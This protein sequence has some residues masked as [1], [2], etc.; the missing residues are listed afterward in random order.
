MRIN[1]VVLYGS[2]ADIRINIDMKTG[3]PISAKM[4]LSVVRR[5]YATSDIRLKGD[6]RA[7][8]PLVY[9]RNKAVIRYGFNGIKK[10]D[11]VIVWGCLCSKD[12]PRK[13]VCDMCGTEQYKELSVVTYVEPSFVMRYTGNDPAKLIQKIKESSRE[14]IDRFI[15]EMKS[16]PIQDGI[17]AFASLIRYT[18]EEAQ[19]KVDACY[20]ISNRVEI[21]GMVC[22]EITDRD[23]YHDPEQG[24]NVRG[25]R[26]QFEMAIMRPRR[27]AE[28]P[29]D[30][31]TDFL[32]VRAYG[33]Q[34]AELRQ[35]IRKGSVLIINGA[36]QTR[37]SDTMF[38]HVCENC[39]HQIVKPGMA[40]EIV[41]YQCEYLKNCGPAY[42]PEEI[43]DTKERYIP[44]V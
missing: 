30:D 33:A 12:A 22:R 14:E 24:D 20:E 13:F 27:I 29:P 19:K 31:T 42:E 4:V 16:A 39:G 3:E 2:V 43:E 25:D 9:S 35:A 17:N 36:I 34:A 21:G 10:G 11:V 15:N 40:T 32:W 38:K 23:Y 1:R 26:I 5:T 44:D 28:D 8:M 41:P 6:A 37:R 18:P 7:D